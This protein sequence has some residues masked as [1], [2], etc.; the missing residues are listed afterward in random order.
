MSFTSLLADSLE[1]GTSKLSIPSQLAGVADSRTDP[2]IDD[3]L[4]GWLTTQQLGERDR[5][6][7]ATARRLRIPL[8]WNLAGGYQNPLRKVL[9]VHDNT[10]RACALAHLGVQTEPVGAS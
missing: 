1:Y 9:D 7:F 6:L 5:L 10:I 4:G 3:P 8:A 2:H